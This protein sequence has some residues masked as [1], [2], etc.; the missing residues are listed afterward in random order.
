MTSSKRIAVAVV[1]AALFTAA[2]RAPAQA[3][4][5]PVSGFIEWVAWAM[6]SAE[7]AYWYGHPDGSHDVR[8]PEWYGAAPHAIHCYECQYAANSWRWRQ[9]ANDRAH[10]AFID[11]IWDAEPRHRKRGSRH[12]DYG[13]GSS[14]QGTYQP[15]GYGLHSYGHGGYSASGTQ[16]YWDPMA[17]WYR[18]QRSNDRA[19]RA[20][21]DYIRH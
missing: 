4:A 17:S 13:Y 1:L 18:I 15:Y 8:A 5:D 6:G 19:H 14:T 10:Q 7:A 16:G 12:R 2:G 11:Y 3:Q 21:I 9:A 20:F